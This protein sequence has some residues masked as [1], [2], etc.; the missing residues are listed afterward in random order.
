MA[1]LRPIV[2]VYINVEVHYR[3]NDSVTLDEVKFQKIR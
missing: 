2:D 3:W 1:T